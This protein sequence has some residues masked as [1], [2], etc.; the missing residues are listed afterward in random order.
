MLQISAIREAAENGST[1]RQYTL[2]RKGELRWYE[3]SIAPMK[4]NGGT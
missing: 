1:G 4:G 2:E 3:L